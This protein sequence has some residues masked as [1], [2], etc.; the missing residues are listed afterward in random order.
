MEIYEDNSYENRGGNVMRKLRGEIVDGVIIVCLLVSA[1]YIF[2]SSTGNKNN[3]TVLEQ[4]VKGEQKA[5]APEYVGEVLKYNKHNLVEESIPVTNIEIPIDAPINESEVQDNSVSIL[6]EKDIYRSMHH[7]I[8]TKIIAI[9]NKIWGEREVTPEYC[10]EL[11][12]TLKE[13]DYEDKETL[14]LFLNNWKNGNFKNGVEEHNYLWSKLG[15][16]VGKAIALRE[17]IK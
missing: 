11:I 16:D 1:V 4:K 3:N 14:I 7:M 13:S 8:N 6:D 17:E 9:D 12:E 10:E 5:I 15:G 2:V